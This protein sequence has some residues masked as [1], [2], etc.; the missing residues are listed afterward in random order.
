MPKPI[1]VPCQRFFRCVKTGFYFTEGMPIGKALPGTAEPEKWKPYKLW[2]GDKFKCEGC[3]AEIVTGFGSGPIRGH[4]EK[5][6]TQIA[7]SLGA[8]KY[9][10][11]DC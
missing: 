10:V 7:E 11:N 8:D 2:A 6:F 9:Q 1:C 4:F 3:G 5:D